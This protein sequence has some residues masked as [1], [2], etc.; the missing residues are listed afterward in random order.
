[1]YKNTIFR[2]KID[3]IK[4]LNAYLINRFIIISALQTNYTS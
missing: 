3:E 2:R 4:L 1:L